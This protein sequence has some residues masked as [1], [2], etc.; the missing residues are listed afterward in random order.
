ML[1]DAHDEGEETMKLVLSD[2]SG[3]RIRDGEAVG[4]IE[5][6]DAIPK[7]WLAR[8][9]RTV[10]DHVVDAVGARVT[11][12][13]NGGSQVTLGG[14]RISLAGRA[15]GAAPGAE[16]AAGDEE[17]AARDT[18]MALADRIG[19]SADAGAWD[20]EADDGLFGD[21]WTRDGAG[22]DGSRSMTGR[23]LLLGSSFVLNLSGA[24]T[25]GAGAADTRWTAWGGAA[26]S[27]FDGEAEGLALDGEVTT[28]TLGAD[29][30][31]GGWLAG[32]AVSSSEG[33]G[34]F[35]D[36][37]A[38]DHESRGSGTL[39]SSL[40]S[41]HPYARLSLSDRLSVWGLLGYGTGELE[42]EVDSGERWTTGTTQEMAAVGARGVLVKA[43]ESGGFE[44]GVRTDA[45]AQR[46]RSDSATGSGGGNLEAADAQTSRV[47][48]VLEGS[49]SFEVGD[50]GVLTPTLEA[51]LRQD[52]GDAETG[53]GVEVGGGLAWARPALG[54]TVEAKARTL[55]AH[56]DTD[57]REWG[58]SASVR[59]DPGASGRGLSLT[60]APAWG[61]AEG[62]AERL[63]GLRDARGLA[64]NDGFEPAG[65]LDAEAGY[66]FGAF[67]GRGL[68]TPFAGLALSQAGDRTWR[69]G[70]RWTLGA[71]LAFGVEG[72]LREAA[73]DNPS[74]HEI[75]FK[76]T[77][78]W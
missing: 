4:M 16:R 76:L 2:P 15:D 47:R 40:S 27:R 51:G 48:L 29:A 7:A 25:D 75:G 57:Y 34:G 46:M 49:R 50:G 59:I 17:A 64:G 66:G 14:Q 35:R 38:T 12:P 32:V 62:G 61:A 36:H 72:A 65:R 45:V 77:A 43:P 22:A 30:A 6:S 69:G 10:A 60:L 70:V 74:E 42:L 55:I 28:F 13:V 37:E 18:L 71:D 56:E 11:A 8:I 26:S 53:T 5:N 9:G 73:N 33:T 31:Q 24:G 63:W 68:T 41:V 67:G 54:L 19:G 78:R 39:E 23:E 44:L 52:G 3:A 58:A 21:G 1:D 20:R